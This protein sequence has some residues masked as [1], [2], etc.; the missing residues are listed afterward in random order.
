[1][2]LKL[3]F[4]FFIFF[5]SCSDRHSQPWIGSYVSSDDSSW[6]VLNKDGRAILSY[7]YEYTYTKDQFTSA[8]LDKYRENLRALGDFRSDW[9]DVRLVAEATKDIEDKGYTIDDAGEEFAVTARN[10]AN[11][12]PAGY[13]GPEGDLL[14]GKWVYNDNKITFKYREQDIYFFGSEINLR[15][16]D[17]NK[18][19]LRKKT[20]VE[21]D[22]NSE[23]EG[24]RSWI[25]N[26]N[27]HFRNLRKP[28]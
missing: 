6:L 23:L 15:K 12:R 26:P 24:K 22:F 28:I 18:L 7:K 9:S 25:S 4:C 8:A 1:M 10:V 11:L 17:N 5:A 14:V 2:K 19:Y 16:Q 20:S 21:F 27:H 3:S 13:Y